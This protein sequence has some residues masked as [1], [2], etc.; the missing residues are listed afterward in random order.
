MN[1]VLKR[2]ISAVTATALLGAAVVFDVPG[3]LLAAAVG[4]LSSDGYQLD[5]SGMLTIMSDAG[6]TNWAKVIEANKAE[7]KT[8]EIQSEVTSIPEG[9]FKGCSNLTSITLAAESKVTSI[10]ESAFKSCGKL[11]GITIPE[12]VTNIGDNAFDL[13]TSLMAITVEENNQNYS[14]DDRGV[15]FN[16]DKTVLFLYPAG[17]RDDYVI[18]NGVTTIKKYAFARSKSA[19]IAIPSG[20]TTIE[21]FAFNSCSLLTS[22]KIPSSVTSIQTHSIQGCGSLKYILLPDNLTFTLS[23]TQSQTAQVRYTEND[24][25]LSVTAVTLG[26]GKTSFTVTDDMN[27]TFVAEDHRSSVS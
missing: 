4:E 15:L 11:A 12:S 21:G 13:C 17:N 5:E 14:S 1:K 9:A 26:E 20:V 18:P 8:V 2:I 6:M 27:I 10:G 23:P 7:V 24:G 25:K 16:K 22:I 3:K 19:S